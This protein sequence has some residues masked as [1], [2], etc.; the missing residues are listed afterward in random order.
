VWVGPF[1]FDELDDDLRGLVAV[2][3]LDLAA[4]VALSFA[5][6]RNYRD[7]ADRRNDSSFFEKLS[8]QIGRVGSMRYLTYFAATLKW[9]SKIVGKALIEAAALHHHYDFVAQFPIRVYSTCVVFEG[10]L[11][12]GSFAPTDLARLLGRSGSSRL[13]ELVQQR[14]PKLHAL[15]ICEGAASA[16]HCELFDTIFEDLKSHTEH[17]VDHFF[18]R[19]PVPSFLAFCRC[20]VKGGQPQVLAHLMAH[21]HLFFDPAIA[22]EMRKKSRD[23]YLGACVEPL[24][25]LKALGDDDARLAAQALQFFESV[26]VPTRSDAVFQS[27]KRIGSVAGVAYLD[28]KY[29]YLRDLPADDQAISEVRQ[30]VARGHFGVAAYYIRKWNIPPRQIIGIA[31]EAFSEEVISKWPSMSPFRQA[32]L[33]VL[34]DLL[35]ELDVPL[36]KLARDFTALEAEQ[37]KALSH[38]PNWVRAIQYLLLHGN[39]VP[40]EVLDPIVGNTRNLTAVRQIVTLFLSEKSN[41]QRASFFY[42]SAL[43]RK[44]DGEIFRL[45]DMFDQRPEIAKSYALL[46]NIYNKAMRLLQRGTLSLPTLVHL[47]E[48]LTQHKYLVDVTTSN[49]FFGRLPLEQCVRLLEAGVPVNSKVHRYCTLRRSGS[50]EALRLKLLLFLERGVPFEE[51]TMERVIEETISDGS[52]S[53]APEALAEPIYEAVRVFHKLGCPWGAA[54][55]TLVMSRCYHPCFYMVWGYML[56]NGVPTDTAELRKAFNQRSAYNEKAINFLSANGVDVQL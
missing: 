45:F 34:I 24:D 51:S 7:F 54:T 19:S 18:E 33:M 31:E 27:V 30:F 47:L 4:L 13:I 21:H 23:P 39:L 46:D 10:K 48:W 22:L 37:S 36:R 12:S 52:M 50:V 11:V 8:S 55:F 53:Q 40:I 29:N 49:R 14:V 16:G 3:F 41:G 5:S 56:T 17:W 2:E 38:N 15:V 32:E 42:L 44:K 9:K 25:I 43:D 20:A 28:G 1:P 26:G 6:K 35:R